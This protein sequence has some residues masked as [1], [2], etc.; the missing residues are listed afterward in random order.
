MASHA[1][2]G[3]LPATRRYRSE[4]HSTVAWR[5][6]TLTVCASPARSFQISAAAR[7]E[8]AMLTCAAAPTRNDDGSCGSSPVSVTAFSAAGS[9]PTEF[10]TSVRIS[11][12]LCISSLDFAHHYL[13][14]RCSAFAIMLKHFSNDVSL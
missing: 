8:A 2:G 10:Q 11:R 1:G 6:S 5:M 13:Q 12:E 7:P 3:D 14:E 9:P 4:R